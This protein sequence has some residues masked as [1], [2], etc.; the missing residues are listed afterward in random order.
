[1]MSPTLHQLVFLLN[2]RSASFR[3]RSRVFFFLAYEHIAF[4]SAY[5]SDTFW[6]NSA[7]FLSIL[8]SFYAI[9]MMTIQHSNEMRQLLSDTKL[10]RIH[11]TC[12]FAPLFLEYC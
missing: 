11:S 7:E 1:M 12:V 5:D 8:S 9:K 4:D 2:Q 3:R 6:L 10:F